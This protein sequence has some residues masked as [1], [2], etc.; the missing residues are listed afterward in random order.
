M[1]GDEFIREFD[2]YALRMAA[3][4]GRDVFELTDDEMSDGY[5]PGETENPALMPLETVQSWLIRKSIRTF[6]N[7]ADAAREWFFTRHEQLHARPIDLVYTH[8]G[9]V[10]VFRA[11]P[12][13]RHPF[14]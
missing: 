8:A 7:D 5:S 9:V 2:A 11:L 14:K 13:R 3:R 12:D 6:H 4:R 1:T 10:S